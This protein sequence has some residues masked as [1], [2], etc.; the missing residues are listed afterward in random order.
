MGSS[1]ICV[2]FSLFPLLSLIRLE[3][4]SS[5]SSPLSSPSFHLLLSSI[6][7]FFFGYHVHEKALILP[8]IPLIIL[9]AQVWLSHFKLISF[10]HSNQTIIHFHLQ[11]AIFSPLLLDLTMVVSSSLSPLLFSTP[12][13]PLRLAFMIFQVCPRLGY[14]IPSS[15]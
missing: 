6:S 14:R 12:E 13:L 11:Y 10:I 2:V 8:L 7:F 9:T 4:S 15:H 1:L 5:S 3:R